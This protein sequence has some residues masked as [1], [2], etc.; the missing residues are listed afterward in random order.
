MNRYILYDLHKWYFVHLYKYDFNWGLMEA[1]KRGDKDL[2]EWM[3]ESGANNWH[4]GLNGACQ[5]GHRDLADLM[6]QKGATNFNEGL[7]YA[8]FGMHR[9]LVEWLIEQG[10]DPNSCNLL[11]H[12]HPTSSK[13]SNP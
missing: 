1:C 11:K 7:H 8:C 2:V 5:S 13:Q 3:I 12:C 10:A 4:W 9:D 6:I